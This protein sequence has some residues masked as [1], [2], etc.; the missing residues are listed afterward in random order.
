[1][2]SV[3]DSPRSPNYDDR[4]GTPI[5]LIVVHYTGMETGA[6][7]LSRLTDAQGKVSSHYFVEEDG[8]IHRLVDEERRAWHAGVG[9]WGDVSDVNGA[10]IGIEIVNPGHE[11]GYRDFPEPQVQSVVDLI[12]DIQERRNLPTTSV[13]GHSDIAP[14]RKD[15]PGE[16]FPWSRLNAEGLAI[17]PWSGKVSHTIPTGAEVF[18]LLKKIGYGVDQFGIA[19]CLVA[20]QRRFCPE[21]LGQSFSPETRAA[22]GEIARR[23]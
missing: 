13:V 21:L 17:G 9:A 18:E 15:D 20:F 16:R 7:A 23:F 14:H 10:S 3:Q 5:S 19:A 8:V 22:I 1:M 11:W 4:A 2:L 12:R 6:E